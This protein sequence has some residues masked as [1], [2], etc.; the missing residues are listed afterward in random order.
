MGMEPE[1]EMSERM[2]EVCEDD[3]M[4]G[5]LLAILHNHVSEVYSPPRV[6]KHAGT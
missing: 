1:D 5:N 4:L 6:T 2:S 3:H